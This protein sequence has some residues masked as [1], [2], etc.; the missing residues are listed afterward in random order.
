MLE[1][2]ACRGMETRQSWHQWTCRELRMADKAGVP[3]DETGGRQE[4]DLKDLVCQAK[5]LEIYSKS[6]EENCDLFMP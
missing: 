2:A 1:K 4:P 5:E 3:R 6:R